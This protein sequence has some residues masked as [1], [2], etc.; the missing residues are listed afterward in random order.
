[1][2]DPSDDPRTEAIAKALYED[3]YLREQF[4]NAGNTHPWSNVGDWHKDELR[5]VALR[6]LEAAE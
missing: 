5:W 6:L 2:R 3:K 1:V 4:R